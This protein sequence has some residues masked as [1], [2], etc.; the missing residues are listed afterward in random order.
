MGGVTFR[1]W[2]LGGHESVRHMWERFYGQ[3]SAVVF[4]VDAADPERLEEAR[5]ELEELL[6][7]EGSM[8]IPIAILA[9]KSDLAYAMTPEDVAR[10]LGVEGHVDE[11]AVGGGAPPQGAGEGPEEGEGKGVSHPDR[12]VRLFRCS[13]FKGVGYEQALRWISTFV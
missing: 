5:D 9:N 10:G 6:E 1:A 4:M 7:A 11:Q 2:D 13:I 12:N 8:D 3:C